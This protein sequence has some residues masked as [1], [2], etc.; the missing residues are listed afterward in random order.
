MIF[1]FT[2]LRLR[3]R[4][5]GRAR[6]SRGLSTITS[7]SVFRS[8]FALVP[9]P[10]CSNCQSAF[11]KSDPGR[12]ALRCSSLQQRFAQKWPKNGTEN[13][14]PLAPNALYFLH[15]R[16]LNYQLLVTYSYESVFMQICKN[17]SEIFNF[18]LQNDD[19][20]YRISEAPKHN[21]NLVATRE[22]I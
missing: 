19:F 17:S 1:L 5:T 10:L 7:I 11:V 13:A 15:S 8:R 16:G 12:G 18:M 6:T 21:A 22:I 4:I 20:W 14:K 3:L 9:P 2:S